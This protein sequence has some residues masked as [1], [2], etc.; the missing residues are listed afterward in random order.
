MKARLFLNRPD[1][2]ATTVRLAFHDC[3]GGCDGC[4]NRNNPDNSGFLF[5]TLDVLD[6]IYEDSYIADMSRADFYILSAVTGL[7][8]SLNFNNVNLTSNF[9][10]PVTFNFKYGRCDCPTSPSTSVD[11]GFPSGHL[12]Y[13]GVIDFFRK[14]FSF[15]VKESVAIMGAHTLGGASGAKGSGFDGFWKEGATAA[16]RLNNRY[17]SLLADRNLTWQH[18][19]RSLVT[20]FGEERWQWE[21]GKTPEGVP[22]PFML[23]AD[24]S[25]IKDIKPN[26][27][28]QSSCQFNTCSDSPSAII[29]EEFAKD[30]N[31]WLTE[32]V[33][34]WDKMVAKGA[35]K[36]RNPHD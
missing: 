3:V 32:F 1:R 11:L 7:E 35:R 30:G 8:E 34:V 16:A 19:D 2:F 5:D 20:G 15:N 26:S 28:G 23:N 17:Y 18:V 14:E 21:A 36:L 22:A 33:K 27:N 25:L 10:S 12:D 13:Q 9:L 4:I 6:Q 24:V 29:V 31:S